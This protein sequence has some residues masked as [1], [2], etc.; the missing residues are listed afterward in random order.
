MLSN[1]PMRLW[2]PIALALIAGGEAAAQ[3]FVSGTAL[4]KE[5]IALPPGAVFVAT[6]EDVSRVGGKAEELGRITLEKPGQP[7]FTFRIAYDPA[8]IDQRSRYAVRARITLD[9]RLLFTTDQMT[10]Y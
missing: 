4:Y 3:S 8:R 1:R 6:L 7:P 2:A 5:R 9:G 10:R